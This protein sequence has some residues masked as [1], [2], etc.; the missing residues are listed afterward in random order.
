[1]GEVSPVEPQY[2]PKSHSSHSAPS[3]NCS[4]LLYVPRGQGSGVPVAT[5][6]YDPAGHGPAVPVAPTPKGNEQEYNY[7]S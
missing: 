7:R 5:G 4:T 6:Q 2:I 1:M 3:V